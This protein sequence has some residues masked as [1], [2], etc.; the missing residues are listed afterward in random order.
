M[1][2]RKILSLIIAVCV[3][4]AILFGLPILRTKIYGV[5]VLG[6]HSGI[7]LADGNTPTPTPNS[8]DSNPSGGGNG[9]G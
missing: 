1:V 7:V 8:G 6:N 2:Q 3:A 5:T 9:G 4:L